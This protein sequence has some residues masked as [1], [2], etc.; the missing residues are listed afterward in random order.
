M[1]IIKTNGVIIKS[2]NYNEYDKL[3]SI[4]TFDFGKILVYAFGVRRENSKNIGKTQILTF[5]EFEINENG[6]K[7]T[8][9]TVNK[10]K[11]FAIFLDDYDKYCCALYFLELINYFFYESMQAEKECFL[12]YY[13][14][15]ALVDNKQGLILTRRVFELKLLMLQGFA[16]NSDDI[17]DNEVRFVWHYIENADMEKV[18]NFKITNAILKKFENEVSIE[19]KNKINKTFRSIEFYEK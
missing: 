14:C 13:A 15:K 6:E 17:K 5:G 9:L 2:E 8:F 16:K 1:N 10:P 19:Y 18:F 12:L 7:K 4:L 3:L 11:S